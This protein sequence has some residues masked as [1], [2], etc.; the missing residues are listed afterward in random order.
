[1]HFLQVVLN[2]KTDQTDYLYTYTCSENLCIG[3][4]VLVPFGH[5]NKVTEGFVFDI[6]DRTDISPSKLKSVLKVI[7]DGVSLN[8]ETIELCCWMKEEYNCRYIDAI[9]CFIPAGAAINNKKLVYLIKEDHTL[10]KDTLEYQI[11]KLLRQKKKMSVKQII[12]ILGEKAEGRVGSLK[13]KGIVAIDEILE[14]RVNSAYASFVRLMDKDAARKYIGEQKNAHRQIQALDLLLEANELS[15]TYLKNEYGIGRETLKALQNKGLVEI[16]NMEKSRIPYLNVDGEENNISEHT[17]EQQEALKRIVPSI[18]KG[19]HRTFLLH[20][21]TGSGKTEVYMQAIRRTLLMGRNAIVLV[22]EISLT[23]QMIERFKGRF[24]ED[25]LAVL[26]SKLSLGERYDEWMRIKRG[27][28]RIVIGAR[29]SL[30]APLKDIGIIIIDE[31]HESS[32]KSDH[33]PKYDT[34]D[35]ANKRADINNAVLIL[36]SATPTVISYYKSQIGEYDRIELKERYNKTPMPLIEVVDMREELQLGNKSIFSKRLYDAMKQNLKAGKQVILFLNRRGYASFVSC[37]SCGYVVK[38]PSCGISMTYHFNSQTC[39]CHYCGHENRTPERCPECSGKYIKFFG[40]GTEKVEAYVKEI[41]PNHTCSR[42]DLDTS[43]KKGSAQ[44][45][46]GDFKK[47]KT[48]ILIGTQIIA[49]GLDFPNVG[50]VGVIAADISL[51]IA[52]YRASERTFQLITQAAGRSGRGT[53][54]GIVIVQTYKPEH[55]AVITASGH[56][57]HSFYENEILMRNQLEYPPFADI[58]QIIISG[59]DEKGTGI[60]ADRIVSDFMREVGTEI[61]N[62]ILGPRPAPRQ[63]IN[64]RFRFQILI[65]CKPV[66][67]I[68]FKGIINN[69]KNDFKDVEQ[70]GYGISIDINPYS[71]M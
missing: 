20:G 9:S 37:R 41:F 4:R 36:G 56:D 43:G 18:E 47:G 1:M 28:V 62:Q 5:G 10:E 21:V 39:V 51:N 38:C 34:I 24:G 71:F 17:F 12:N 6:S 14:S 65:K 46:L 30:F 49:K 61:R 58:M 35:T 68:Q 40:V 60:L 16:F 63:K 32:Y 44:K 59:K 66:D 42:L 33:T 57:Y 53:E 27:N 64:D 29:S 45:I 3:D 70:K 19:I 48:D 67:R 15:C 2:K 31:E 23:L 52:D 13:N 50:L 26:H 11:V 55:Y 8:K 69:I 54:R 25:A 22:P 7:R